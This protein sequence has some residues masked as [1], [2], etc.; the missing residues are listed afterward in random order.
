MADQ[1]SGNGWR[2]MA[3]DALDPYVHFWLEGGDRVETTPEKGEKIAAG[4]IEFTKDLPAPL[5]FL[6]IRAPGQAEG[7]Q[8]EPSSREKEINTTISNDTRRFP[9]ARSSNPSWNNRA[10]ERWIDP[11]FMTR[12]PVLPEDAVIVGIMDSGVALHH[13]RTSRRAA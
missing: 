11:D 7:D 3:L 10:H 12:L 9:P 4:G 1:T 8:P 5:G 13:R 6:N 2:P